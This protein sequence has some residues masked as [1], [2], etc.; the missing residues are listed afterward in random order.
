MSK[1]LI[2]DGAV[3]TQLENY[4]ISL[5]LPIWS[6]DANIKYP[7]TIIKIHKEYILAGADIITANTF[8]STPWTYRKAGFSNRKAFN[9]SKDSFFYGYK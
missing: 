9:T 2:L 3:G 6:A 7:E 4:N 5:D 1:F 8:R